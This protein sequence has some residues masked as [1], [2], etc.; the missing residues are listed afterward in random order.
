MGRIDRWR[1]MR[2]GKSSVRGPE[3]CEIGR[4]SFG[5][6]VMVGRMVAFSRRGLDCD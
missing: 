4:W 3:A 6:A 1:R 2:C 5:G